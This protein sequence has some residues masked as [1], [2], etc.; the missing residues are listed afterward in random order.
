MLPLYTIYN[1]PVDYPG[2]FVVR[3]FILDTPTDEVWVGDTLA[4]ARN[5]IPVGLVCMSRAA[6]D[7][8]HI[9]EVWL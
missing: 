6:S 1:S 5:V 4:Q 2:K 8:A 3:K 9:V 7:E